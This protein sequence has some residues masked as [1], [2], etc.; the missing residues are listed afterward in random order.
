MDKFRNGG[1][2][3]HVI[4]AEFDNLF[5]RHLSFRILAYISTIKRYDAA[6]IKSARLSK[7]RIPSIGRDF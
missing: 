3:Y 2:I 4:F 1:L 7:V 5:S 6:E